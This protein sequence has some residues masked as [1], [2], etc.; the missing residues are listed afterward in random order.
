MSFSNEEIV[1]SRFFKKKELD[2]VFLANYIHIR[3]DLNIEYNK[4]DI[5]KHIHVDVTMNS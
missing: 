4:K 5:S 3:W 2:I 1:T